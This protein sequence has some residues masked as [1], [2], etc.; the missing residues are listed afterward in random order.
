MPHYFFDSSAIIKRYVEE[1]GS[2]WVRSLCDPAAGNRLD[3]VTITRVEVSSALSRRCREGTVTAEDRDRLSGQFLYDC[4]RQYRLVDCTLLLLDLA[5]ELCKRH[6]LRA[7]DAVQMAAAKLVNQAL[8]ENRLPA[9]IFVS[10]DDHLLSVAANDG[11]VIEN[12]AIHP[13]Q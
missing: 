5:A 1:T 8:T 9:L 11:L 6:P 3:L 12:P 13:E 4:T 2:G 7:F 10:A